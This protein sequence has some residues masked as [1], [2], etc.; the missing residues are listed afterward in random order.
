MP[1]L[2]NLTGYVILLVMNMPRSIDEFLTYS[3]GKHDTIKKNPRF[4]SLSAEV[5]A[6]NDANE[7]LGNSQK[8]FCAKPRTVSRATR[9]ADNKIART[10]VRILANKIQTMATADPANAEK[11]ITDAGFDIKKIVAKQKQKSSVVDGPVSGSVIIYGE[12]Q[13]SHNFRISED[14]I[15]WTVLVGSTNIRKIVRGLTVGKTYYFQWGKTLKDGEEGQWSQTLS[16][17]VR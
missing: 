8:G 9:D 10:C 6:L 4:A 2:E 15:T 1:T 16:I 3:K 14:G 7:N 17:V 12:G 13:G 11:I 5:D